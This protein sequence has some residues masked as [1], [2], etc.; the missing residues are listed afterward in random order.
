MKIA[1]RGDLGRVGV[2]SYSTDPDYDSASFI[3]NRLHSQKT[4][5]PFDKVEVHLDE[6]EKPEAWRQSLGPR[7]PVGDSSWNAYRIFTSIVNESGVYE[8]S[9]SRR[10]G[11]P[12]S[13]ERIDILITEVS[14]GLDG[15]DISGASIVEDNTDQI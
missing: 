6:A 14:E 7:Y 5:F 12:L 3:M 11:G 9:G 4:G 2:A 13:S 1:A 10:V 8:Q 15:I